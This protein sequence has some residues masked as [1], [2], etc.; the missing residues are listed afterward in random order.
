MGQTERIEQPEIDKVL[1]DETHHEP[2]YP[3]VERTPEAQLGK[4]AIDFTQ[5]DS[6]GSYIQFEEE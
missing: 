4:T 5:F 3:T 1:Y 2:R 6:M